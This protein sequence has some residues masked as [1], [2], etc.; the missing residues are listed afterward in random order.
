MR[1]HHTDTVLVVLDGSLRS[2][3]IVDQV[4]QSGRNVAVTG[5]R[6][7]DLVPFVNAEV[8]DRILAIVADPAESAQ[9][10]AVI[11]RAGD[12]MGPV[13]MIVDPGGLLGDVASADR[14]V[15]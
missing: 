12:V 14:K 13:V 9:I 4:L 3:A 10:D 6:Q 7:H 11:E 15:A 1:N 2:H 5:R 8:H